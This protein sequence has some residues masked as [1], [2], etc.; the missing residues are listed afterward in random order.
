MTVWEKCFAVVRPDGRLFVYASR[1]QADSADAVRA[2]AA[3]PAGEPAHQILV[4]DQLEHGAAPGLGADCFVLQV[5]SSERATW[6]TTEPAAAAG[7]VSSCGRAARVATE[8]SVFF[9]AQG[10]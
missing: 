6:R 5:V 2:E 7:W 1:E 3:V 10:S 9:A 4:A 8:L